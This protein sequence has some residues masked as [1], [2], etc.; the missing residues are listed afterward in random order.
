MEFS[1]EISESQMYKYYSE[2]E[3]IN[4]LIDNKIIT[5]TEVE[6]ASEQQMEQLI[7]RSTDLIA[8]RSET[9][10]RSRQKAET[11]LGLGK[12][13]KP[14]RAELV[15]RGVVMALFL[16]AKYPNE[17]LGLDL[18]GSRT[19]SYMTP[20]KDSDQDMF[21][22]IKPEDDLIVLRPL[23]MDETI[24][25]WG[26]IILGAEPEFVYRDS[27]SLE[28]PPEV[29]AKL[30]PQVCSDSISIFINPQDRNKF[31]EA[32]KIQLKKPQ[33]WNVKPIDSFKF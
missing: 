15:A 25:K 19:V 3:A 22:Y 9:E 7:A 1:S 14:P 24:L 16:K 30:D 28:T 12:D 23:G 5:H 8:R 31:N 10:Y 32:Y 29:N 13:R 4:S 27:R 18:H 2:A 26:K 21:I 17:F 11:I 6:N 20:R 33:N